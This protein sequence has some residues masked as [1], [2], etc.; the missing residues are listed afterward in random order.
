MLII[1]IPVIRIISFKPRFNSIIIIFIERIFD[2]HKRI[3]F[4]NAHIKLIKFVF[5]V[6]GVSQINKTEIRI[7]RNNKTVEIFGK[8]NE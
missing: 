4:Y 6:S 8:S 3:L 5:C 7:F 1:K 2:D